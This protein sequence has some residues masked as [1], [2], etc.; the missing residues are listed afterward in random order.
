MHLHVSSHSYCV[1]LPQR[2]QRTQCKGQA[3]RA[4]EA[5]KGTHGDARTNMLIPA[6]QTQVSHL[7]Q[8]HA[9]RKR[10]NKISAPLFVRG[11]VRRFCV[12]RTKKDTPGDPH[13][14][15]MPTPSVHKSSQLVLRTPACP[16][17]RNTIPQTPNSS[18]PS[19]PSCATSDAA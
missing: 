17:K 16:T 7:L 6:Q 8:P 3:N 14:K 13:M 10:Y 11:R 19:P 12:H 9:E 1:L 15:T 4:K 2:V 18:Q 5:C